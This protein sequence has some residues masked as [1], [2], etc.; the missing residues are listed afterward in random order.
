[1]TPGSELR[2]DGSQIPSFG[3]NS[4]MLM[5]NAGIV[6]SI[7]RLQLAA[8]PMKMKMKMN[9]ATL[10]SRLLIQSTHSS[11]IVTKF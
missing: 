5:F 8:G 6:V 1:M 9:N 10:T 3:K 2:F 7:V 11:T 4:G